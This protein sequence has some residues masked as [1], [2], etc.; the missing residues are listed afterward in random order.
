MQNGLRHID[1]LPV[2][3]S[4]DLGRLASE[5]IEQFGAMLRFLLKGLGTSKQSGWDLVSYLAFD[6]GYTS[7]LLRLGYSDGQS[8]K[9]ELLELVSA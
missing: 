5:S 6:K 2:R 9:E 4:S 1:A 3:P 8:K 7:K